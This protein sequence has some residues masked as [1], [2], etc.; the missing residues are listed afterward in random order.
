MKKVKKLVVCM[1][2]AVMILASSLPVYAASRPS[3]PVLTN[4]EMT[5]SGRIYLTWKA[6]NN[7]DGYRIKFYDYNKK[8][9]SAVYY[10]NRYRT[11]YSAVKNANTAYRVS[12]TSFKRQNGKKIFSAEC[13]MFMCAPRTFSMVSSTSSSVTVKWKKLYG[14]SGYRIYRSTS[15]NSGYKYSGALSA[16][17]TSAKIYDL[18]TDITYFRITPYRTINGKKYNFPRGTYYIY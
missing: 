17:A 10:T 11:N 7:A 5:E 18:G 6:V 8:K 15:P 9:W 16:N 4:A 12:V 13:V 2:A 3:H 1:L 14:I